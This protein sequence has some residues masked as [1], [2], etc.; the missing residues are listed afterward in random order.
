M[1]NLKNFKDKNYMLSL[2]KKLRLRVIEYRNNYLDNNIN[3]DKYQS[4]TAIELAIIF[5]DMYYT[6]NR[7]ISDKELIYFKGGRF[8]SDIIG[9]DREFE[10]IYDMYYE[11][12]NE[13]KNIFE[14]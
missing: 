1:R 9:S 13:I 10:D 3:F 2:I 5:A 14:K 4:C 8:V 12:S 7:K 11:L 6:I